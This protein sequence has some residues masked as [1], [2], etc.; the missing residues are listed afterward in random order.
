MQHETRD[1]KHAKRLINFLKFWIPSELNGKV[2]LIFIMLISTLL[3][4]NFSSC[5]QDLDSPIST[6]LKNSSDNW[7]SGVITCPTSNCDADT[8]FC[9]QANCCTRQDLDPCNYS[10]MGDYAIAVAFEL[11]KA[12]NNCLQRSFSIECVS[13]PAVCYDFAYLS[14]IFS[15]DP[16]ANP[17]HF[18]S[19]AECGTYYCEDLGPTY[20]LHR[21]MSIAYQNQIAAHI[22]YLATFALRPLCDPNVFGPNCSA[23]VG[24]IYFSVCT[25]PN[26]SSCENLGDPCWDTKIIIH[27]EYTCCPCSI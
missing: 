6:Q 2:N 16:T 3:L 26:A 12:T 22:I 13:Q 15:E 1:T 21:P 18:C 8:C 25:D 7:A 10:N 27:F 19:N 11:C 14:G 17:F 9:Y 4:S 5:K 24:N 23:R 20:Y